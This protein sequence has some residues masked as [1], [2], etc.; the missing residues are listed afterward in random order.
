[1]G[2]EKPPDRYGSSR[3][4]SKPADTIRPA[5]PPVTNDPAT[6]HRISAVIRLAS[7]ESPAS[8][9]TT[10]FRDR[11]SWLH[12]SPPTRLLAYARRREPV[13]FRRGEDGC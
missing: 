6:V 7:Q 8:L 4:L 3:S 13:L 2:G 12:S 1:M 10:T 5:N 11:P 9:I